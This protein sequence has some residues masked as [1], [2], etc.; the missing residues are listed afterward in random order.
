MSTRPELKLGSH[1]FRG[2]GAVALF[3][4]MVAVFINANLGAPAGFEGIREAAGGITHVIGFAMFDIPAPI[5]EETG[6][7]SFLVAFEIIDIV[8]VA[9]L[10]AAVMLARRETGGSVVSALRSWGGGD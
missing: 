4:V 1:L 7:E 3:G 8:L 9:A 6:T 2:L 5:L 10:V